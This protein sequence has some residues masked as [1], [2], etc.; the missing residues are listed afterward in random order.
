LASW[1]TMEQSS[2]TPYEAK[3]VALIAAW[4]ARQPG[5][6][7][8]TLATLRRPVAAL[9]DK[10]V[11]AELART[12]FAR[13][14]RAADWRQGRDAVQRSLGIDHLGE[15]YDGPLEQCDELVKKT[16][17]ISREIIT[18]ESLLAGAGGVATELLEL[19]AEIMLAL[20][21][22]HRVAACYGYP[23][24]HPQDEALVMAIIGLSLLNDPADRLS[25]S[26]SIRGLEDGTL[27]R[28]DEQRL[29]RTA[30]TRLKDEVGDDLVQQ[31]GSELVEEKVEEGIPFLGAAV[32]LMLDNAFIGG[33]EK[34]AQFTFQERWLREHGKVNEITPAASPNDDNGTIAKGV[35]Q[36]VYTTG[37]AVGFGV[38][39]PVALIGGA[40]ATVLPAAAT[41]GLKEGAATATSDV[42]R[43][44]AGVR[45]HPDPEQRPT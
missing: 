11:P 30:E 34:A 22:V 23:L 43:L 6:M 26:R 5:L 7:G 39:F 29:A 40:V 33:V 21:T 32:G 2:L 38:V 36:A 28:G 35:S 31:I 4:K 8:R 27:T 12:M 15:L 20:R 19:P 42:D 24:D 10:L 13:V 3:Q 17:T 41:D 9:S 37:Y 16:A 44:I 25:A 18:S 14:H 1:A 45:G